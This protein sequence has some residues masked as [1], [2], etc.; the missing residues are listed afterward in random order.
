MNNR[1]PIGEETR[2]RLLNWNIG[3]IPSERLSGFFLAHEN[4]EEIE[5]SQPG[6]GADGKKDFLCKK[7]G[8]LWIGACYFGIGEKDFVRDI[9]KKFKKDLAGV[10]YN[11]A[12]GIV[13][14][15][16]QKLSE[17]Q[18]GI[19]KGLT[20]ELKVDLILLD[21]MVQILNSV[22]GY[23]ARREYLGIEMYEEEKAA[24]FKWQLQE[25]K[26]LNKAQFDAICGSNSMLVTNPPYVGPEIFKHNNS[27]KSKRPKVY[28][29]LKGIVT[30]QI[31]NLIEYKPATSN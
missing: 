14:I 20:K 21:R 15:T 26:S 30:E 9:K 4:Y 27:L 18:K 1:K 6:G 5:P 3:Q 22:S 10:R 12:K 31:F 13:F 11:N 19:L 8:L 7:D 24:F 17:H 2:Y 16:N 28:L 25:I 23:G 29:I